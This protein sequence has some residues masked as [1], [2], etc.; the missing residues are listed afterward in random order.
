MRDGP[1]S[2]CKILHDEALPAEWLSEWACHIILL[3]LLLLLLLLVV[4]GFELRALCLLDKCS[5]TCATLLAL[6]AFRLFF[7]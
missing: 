5:V 7:R 3:L 1:D 4:L 6:F 2:Y